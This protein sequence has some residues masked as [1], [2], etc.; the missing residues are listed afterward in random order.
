M[1]STFTDC[2]T[3]AATSDSRVLLL[4]GDHGYALFDE[5]R[6]DCP[7]QYFNAGVAEQNMIG[8]AAG[9]AKTGFLPVVYGLSAFVPIRV[10]EQIKIDLCYENL[11]AILIGDGAGV[12]YSHLG[13]SHQSTEDIAALRSVPNINIFSPC[14]E[15]EMS[16]C[17][18]Q[19]FQNRQTNYIR[20]G[21]ADLGNI[22]TNKVDLESKKLLPIKIADN[23][24]TTF[25]ATGSMANSALK[26][27]TEDFQQSN[28]YSAPCLKPF[29]QKQL[30]QVC[31]NS[32]SI[33]TLE[34]HSINGGLGSIICEVAAEN[35]LKTPI[36]RLGIEDEFSTYCGSHQYLLQE[37]GLDLESL[38][39]KIGNFLNSVQFN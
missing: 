32:S 36:L 11:P 20:I 22:H 16:A 2:L 23:P 28:V 12:V 35:N 5:F 27:A 26:L 15:Y 34:E 4:T 24:E 1:R 7:V 13:S 17:F 14:D 21:K 19:A 8:V 37:H 18:E 25:I 9:L 30:L 38:K 6:K 39:E 3:K 33:I 10:L 29:D 31:A